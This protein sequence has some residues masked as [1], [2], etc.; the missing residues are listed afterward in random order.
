MKKLLLCMLAMMSFYTNAGG[1]IKVKKINLSNLSA[2]EGKYV[3]AF[4][5]SARASGFS[6]ENSSPRINQVLEKSAPIQIKGGKAALPG[7]ELIESGFNIF[8]YVKIV[9]HSTNTN[10][11]VRN[12]DNT[13]PRGVGQVENGRTE[14]IKSIFVSKERLGSDLLPASISF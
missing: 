12:I 14:E 2:F 8:N 5:L 13:I 11:I 7:K 10:I 4:Y 3:T 9:V 1:L 6:Y